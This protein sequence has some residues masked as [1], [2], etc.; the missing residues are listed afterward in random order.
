MPVKDVDHYKIWEILPR[1]F[2]VGPVQIEDQFHPNGLNVTLFE[3][4]WIA[5]PVKKTVE[6]NGQ[7]TI[8]P[9]LQKDIHLIGY[10]ARADQSKQRPVSVKNQ[11]HD[12]TDWGLGPPRYLLVPA[13]K[14]DGGGTA[15]DELPPAKQ[16]DHYLCYEVGRRAL[17]VLK[18]VRLQDQ[19]DLALSQTEYFTELVPVYFG[20]PLK[21]KVPLKS[22]AKKE[23]V[24]A[25]GDVHL[26]IY[27]LLEP[28]V[29]SRSRLKRSSANTPS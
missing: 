19:F 24:L 29:T 13:T 28:V 14:K 6:E 23:N 11:F 5:N 7:D 20:V 15:P 2:Q 16:A 1:E 4:R 22:G 17:S 8:T 18:E 3:A 26:A 10:S 25:H 27:R 21:T 12:W 9:I